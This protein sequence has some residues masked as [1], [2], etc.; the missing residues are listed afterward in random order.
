MRDPARAGV[1]ALGDLAIHLVDAFSA[2]GDLPRLVAVSLDRDGAGRGDVGGSALGR[3]RDVPITL[4]A[5]SV[6]RPP[7]L[8]LSISGARAT[9][10]LRD[11]ALELVSDRGNPERWIGAPP[12]AGDALRAFAVRLRARRLGRDGLA[13]AIRA[14]E[15]L[16]RAVLLD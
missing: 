8:E 5:S 12:D 1:G 16:E 11:G 10:V 15:A 6:T 9:A 13:P 7:G 3:W 4:R 14:Q 2:L